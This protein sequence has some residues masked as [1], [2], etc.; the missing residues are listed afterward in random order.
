M[1]KYHR[2]VNLFPPMS[3]SEQTALR[4][5]IKKHGLKMPIVVWRGKVIDG[6]NRYEACCDLGIDEF[7]VEEFEG[8]EDEMLAHVVSLNMSRRQLNSGQKACVGVELGTYRDSLDSGK[9][10]DSSK[11]LIEQVADELGTNRQYLYS[12]EK[13][14][15]QDADLFSQVRRGDLKLTAA[16]AAMTKLDEPA[17][18]GDS[19]SDQPANP[20]QGVQDA[21]GNPVPTTMEPAFEER[22]NYRY[23]VSLV[24][25]VRQAIREIVARKKG[26]AFLDLNEVEGNLKAAQIAIKAAMPYTVCPYC[27]GAKC[28]ACKSKGWVSSLIYDQAPDEMKGS[29]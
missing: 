29:N 18:K 6:R 8:S 7:E 25:E 9:S 21:F 13:L 22:D 24:D 2:V 16:M 20:P 27:E 11:R 17:G 1:M 4:A 19:V 3:G 28:D 5:D 14:K 12:A 26:T 23:A 10:G 15:Q